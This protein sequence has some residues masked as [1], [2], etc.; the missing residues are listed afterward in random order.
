MQANELEFNISKPI[1]TFIKSKNLQDRNILIYNTMKPSIAFDMRKP[2]ISVYDGSNTLA[3]EVQ[4]EKDTVWKNYFYDLTD[5]I[6]A[7]RLNSLLESPSVLVCYKHPLPESRQWMAKKFSTR[8]DIGK[9]H[10]YY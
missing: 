4:F 2:V 3:R 9:W 7:N 6:D 10:I 5:S 8:K 1:T